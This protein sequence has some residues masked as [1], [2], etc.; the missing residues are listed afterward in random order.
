MSIE[1]VESILAEVPDLETYRSNRLVR[2]AVE[3]EL[4]IIG[5]ATKQLLDEFPDTTF[6]DSSKIIGLRNRIIHGYADIDDGAI[7]TIAK[8][9]LPG[10]RET[11][12]N[13]IEREEN[14]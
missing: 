10:L 4:E 5:E 2:R 8:T 3:R 14:A 13:L 1:S 7:W 12:E 9:R 11:I 6:T